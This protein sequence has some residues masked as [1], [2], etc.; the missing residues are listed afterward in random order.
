MRLDGIHHVTNI[1][2]DAP[3]E[4]RLLH[5]HAGL[6]LVKKSVNQDDPTVYHLFYADEQGSPG[7]DITFFEYPGARAGPRGRRDD[8]HGRLARRLRRR[9]ST[10]GPSGSASSVRATRVALQRP[11]GPSARARRRARPGRA[12]DRRP[13]GD[14]A[15]ARAAGLRGRA[16]VRARLR[17]A[18]RPVPRAARLRARGRALGRRAA[19]RAA[20][21]SST[22]RRPRSPASPVPAPCTTSRG[23]RRWTS[24]RRGGSASPRRAAARRR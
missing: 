21:G 6:R 5:G 7:A 1:T 16:R 10:S 17:G 13:S 19:T 12:A 11:G 4:R 15:R 23:R 24:T 14:P 3:R 18:E 22:S 2:G 8:P 20:A 9:R